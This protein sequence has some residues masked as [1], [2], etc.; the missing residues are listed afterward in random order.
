MKILMA[1]VL[2]FSTLH[3]NAQRLYLSVFGGV[4][5]YQGDLQD[6]KFTFDQ[7]HPAFGAGVVYEISDKLYA[8]ANFTIGKVSGDDKNSAKNELR[9]LNFT[10]SIR[11][12]HIGAEYNVT[13]LYEFPMTPYI[14]A[15]VSFYHFDP[16]TTM[17]GSS[18]NIYLQ[19]LGTEGQ[20]F[21]LKRTKYNLNQ[22]AIPFGGGVKFAL[23]ENV[24]FGVEIGLRKLFTD[25][26][27][28]VSTTYIKDQAILTTHNG[29]LSTALSFRGDELRPS[30][31]YPTTNLTRGNP[32]SKD[33]YY[34]S[35]L[36]LNVR[37][38]STNGL[39]RSKKN[40]I[41]CPRL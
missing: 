13:N 36:T 33:W 4:S 28:D 41:G 25:Y 26:L 5:N 6:K 39:A 22:F 10:S 3:T 24:R 40:P 16:Y 14:F 15:G 11:D 1:T 37:M 31:A 12:I 2:L 8:R 9:N 34:F 21:Y 17:S 23:T 38:P 20:G 32:G 18:E 7:S 35:L 29:A 30:Q 19:P 27:D